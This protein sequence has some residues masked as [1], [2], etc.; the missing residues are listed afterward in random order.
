MTTTE[1]KI[2]EQETTIKTDTRGRVRVPRERQE[3]LLDEFERSGVSALKFARLVGV[4][5]PTLMNW[6]Q[7]RRQA[8]RTVA[9]QSDIAD[10]AVTGTTELNRRRAV[11][12]RLFEALAEVNG[13]GEAHRLQV[14]LPGGAR[15][16]IES[17]AQIRLA[18]ELL[19]LLATSNEVAC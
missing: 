14:D 2:A 10:P 16:Q 5:Y 8:R 3:M 18:A 17:A 7:K 9:A 15:L 1:P 19:R 11:P 13:R 12:I 6:I 4:K